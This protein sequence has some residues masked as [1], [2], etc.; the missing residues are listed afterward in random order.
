MPLC[1][2]STQQVYIYRQLGGY[3]ENTGK[4]CKESITVCCEENADRL[5]TAGECLVSEK[6]RGWWRW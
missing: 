1:H 6:N 5:C 3:R 2:S 4:C